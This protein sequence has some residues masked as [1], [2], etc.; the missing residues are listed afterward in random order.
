MITKPYIAPI[1]SPIAKAAEG[2]LTTLALTVI[3][4]SH[5]WFVAFF[6]M[7]LP[8]MLKRFAVIATGSAYPVAATIVTIATED[9]DNACD[10]WLTYWS[11]FSLLYLGMISAERLVGRVP[12]LYTLCLA[13]TFYLMLPIFD[14]SNAVFREILV[15]LFRQREALLLKDARKLAKNMVRQLPADRYSEAGNAA[16]AAFLEE[17]NRLQQTERTTFS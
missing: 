16:A 5:L 13:V 10:K 7:A 2:L 3:N 4:A 9:D 1:V 12:G 15:P 14:G 11:C 8:A 17:V 6:F